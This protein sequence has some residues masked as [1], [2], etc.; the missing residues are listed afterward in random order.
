MTD[1]LEGQLNQMDFSALNALIARATKLRDQ[2]RSEAMVR[3]QTDAE[4]LGA[5]VKDTNGKKRR[6]RKPKRQDT[7]IEE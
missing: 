4:L 1:D 2:R 6:G 7:A 3:L 5:T